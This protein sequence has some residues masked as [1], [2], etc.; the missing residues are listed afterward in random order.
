MGGRNSTKNT[1]K[2]RGLVT[3]RVK[4]NS[5]IMSG[6]ESKETIP[7]GSAIKEDIY[8]QRKDVEKKLK[9]EPL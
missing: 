9:G 2:S 4:G 5:H 3:K 7:F 6:K 8:V 1:A